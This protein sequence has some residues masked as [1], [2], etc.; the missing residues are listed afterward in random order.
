LLCV[1]SSAGELVLDCFAGSGTTGEAAARLGRRFLLGDSNPAA[2]AVMQERLAFA[3][4]R[5]V[6]L[7]I[8]LQGAAGSP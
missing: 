5:T 6:R 7:D 4:P 1:H 2:L 8:G 3:S